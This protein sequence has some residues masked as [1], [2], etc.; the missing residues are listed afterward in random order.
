MRFW[1]L[2]SRGCRALNVDFG[3]Y[4][5]EV[6]GQSCLHLPRYRGTGEHDHLVPYDCGKP[7]L[8]WQLQRLAATQYEKNLII[9]TS[10]E[11]Q[12]EAIA[13]FCLE[14]NIKCFR[15][16]EANVLERFFLA[17]EKFYPQ[18]EANDLI[19]RITGDCPFL[20]IVESIQCP[21]K[22][23]RKKLLDFATKNPTLALFCSTFN[24]LVLLNDLT[25]NNTCF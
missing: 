17:I 18:I 14:R 15:G 10:A 12:D 5:S 3:Y 19:V 13:A 1:T 22:A 25:I 4:V 21:L 20:D 24:L 9:A 16:S 23:V 8:D 7:L 2:T 6:G 11:A